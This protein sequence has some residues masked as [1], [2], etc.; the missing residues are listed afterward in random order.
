MSPSALTRRT[1]GEGC[2][3]CPYPKIYRL[4]FLNLSRFLYHLFLPWN[5]RDTACSIVT[6]SDSVQ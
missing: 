2:S 1:Y 6:W 5:S 4:H 3:I